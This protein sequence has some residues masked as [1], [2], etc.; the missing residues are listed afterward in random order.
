MK[1]YFEMLLVTGLIFFS[2]PTF[3]L[4]DIS[5][6]DSDYEFFQTCSEAG[7][8][9]QKIN[10]SLGFPIQIIHC[11]DTKYK[12][13]NSLLEKVWR[14]Y[15]NELPQL[16]DFP[17]PQ[18]VLSERPD[19]DAAILPLNPAT[20]K[21]PWLIVATTGLIDT[22]MSDEGLMGIL[23][24]ELGHAILK[25]S[26]P[27]VPTSTIKFYFA[28]ERQEPLGFLQSDDSEA[29]S[30][31]EEWLANAAIA[32]NA[33]YTE[34]NGL[35]YASYGNTIFP[36]VFKSILSFDL[37]NS[38]DENCVKVKEIKN[39]YSNILDSTKSWFDF[40][41]Y[42]NSQNFVLLNLETQNFVQLISKCS[43]PN[44]KLNEILEDKNILGSL[45][46]T[47]LWYGDNVFGKVQSALRKFEIEFDQA[48]NYILGAIKLTKKSHLQLAAIEKDPRF[49]KLRYYNMEEQADDLAIKVLAKH[50]PH[51]LAVKTWMLDTLA[52]FSSLPGVKEN[53]V[54][55][56]TQILKRGQTPGYGPII[57]MHHSPCFRAY[58]N[59]QMVEYLK[60]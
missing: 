2:V 19:P 40:D 57:D 22:K 44:R 17:M 27:R 37:E 36:G 31:G 58:H 56:C 14:A 46:S 42:P 32:G 48:K 33:S 50:T 45:S 60:R 25:H 9:A 1:T 7:A 38:T 28:D 41:L 4:S 16:A 29:R 20:K 49:K 12:T 43:L 34:Q 39:N 23:A 59:E 53:Y 18:I 6:L 54:V 11:E 15:Q 52:F 5:Q 8:L 26:L 10:T 30:L 21:I 13:L 24:H 55:K 47:Q 35:P 3:A 51:P